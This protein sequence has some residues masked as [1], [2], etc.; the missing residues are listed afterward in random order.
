MLSILLSKDHYVP[1][2]IMLKIYLW[3]WSKVIF[4]IYQI[5]RI[6]MIDEKQSALCP[7][8]LP[9]AKKNATMYIS[10]QR[11]SESISDCKRLTFWSHCWSQKFYEIILAKYKC[12]YNMH[13]LQAGI[14]ASVCGKWQTSYELLRVYIWKT[15][16]PVITR[17]KNYFK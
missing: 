11:S 16:V 17:H 13:C 5:H 12:S 9:G 6:L 1:Y 2:L 15:F 10:W 7:F 3:S 4:I 8:P 14:Y